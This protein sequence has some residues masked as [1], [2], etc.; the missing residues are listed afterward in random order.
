[1]TAIKKKT[2]ADSIPQW[3]LT[4]IHTSVTVKR[5]FFSRIHFCAHTHSHINHKHK[6]THSRAYPWLNFCIAQNDQLTI[7]VNLI[8]IHYMPNAIR[9]LFGAIVL[10]NV[11]CTMYIRIVFLS[12]FFL[13]LS[14]IMNDRT[15]IYLE[16]GHDRCYCW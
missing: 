8:I 6:H 4:F 15:N 3:Y 13:L 1:M 10:V 14:G 11:H 7:A 16:K 9:K 2:N 5:K 12:L